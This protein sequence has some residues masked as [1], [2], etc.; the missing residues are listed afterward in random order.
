MSHYRK[1]KVNGKEYHFNIGRDFVKIKGIGDIK[2]NEFFEGVSNLDREIIRRKPVSP[3]MIADYINGK[4]VR[5]IKLKRALPQ[6]NCK[7]SISEKHWHCDPFD[8]EIYQD[9]HYAMWC[10]ECLERRSWDI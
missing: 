8:A 2:K 9:Y 7:K 10:E 1:I 5:E 3:G 6:C 4:K